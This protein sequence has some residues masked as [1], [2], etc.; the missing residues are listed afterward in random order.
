VADDPENSRS[1]TR[2]RERQKDG[3][4]AAG[5]SGNP[6]GRPVGSRNKSVILFEGILDKA[7]PVLIRKAIAMAKAGDSAVM[8]ALLPLLLPPRKER[9]GEFP[10]PG[11]ESAEDALAASRLLVAGV[12]NGAI[13]AEE[14]AK[15]GGLLEL[16]AKLLEVH[17]L[18]SRINA[19]EQERGI[20]S[21][22][23][24]IQ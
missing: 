10:L 3:R 22:G 14:A 23:V 13:S 17:E 5:T 19:L 12:A 16:H 4:F 11:I 6:A 8:R 21:T 15:L 1:E 24:A 20:G 9:P 7:G 2:T 18:E